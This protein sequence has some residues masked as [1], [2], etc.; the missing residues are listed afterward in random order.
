MLLSALRRLTKTREKE[1]IKRADEPGYMHNN[2][3]KSD[4]IPLSFSPGGKSS[5]AGVRSTGGCV[6]D[7]DML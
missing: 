3:F 2:P 7:R 5:Q 1:E 6:N 4:I